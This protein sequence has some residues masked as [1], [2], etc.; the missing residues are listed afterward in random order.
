MNNVFGNRT[1]IR[2]IF[3]SYHTTIYIYEINHLHLF[4]NQI[5]IYDLYE[6]EMS[7]QNIINLYLNKF[8]NIKSVFFSHI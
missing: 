3:Y 7:K 8:F 2:I 4:P 1:R 5:T 6:Y